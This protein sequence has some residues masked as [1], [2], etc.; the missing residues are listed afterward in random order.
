MNSQPLH[1]NEVIPHK[2]TRRYF[3]AKDKSRL[4][5]EADSASPDQL[6]ALL[7]REGIFSSDLDAWRKE[8]DKGL[9]NTSSKKKGRPV[10]V[11]PKDKLI[12]QLERETARWKERAERAETLVEL[13][14]KT[15]EL[16][17]ISLSQ[18]NEKPC[19]KK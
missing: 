11:D 15:A 8:R 3:Y 10:T 2:H 9:L 4:L 16:L 1:Q 17:K 5:L 7:R 14:K 13:Q 6:G 18:N 19:S 12:A